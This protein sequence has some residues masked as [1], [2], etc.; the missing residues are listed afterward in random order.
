MIK[1]LMRTKEASLDYFC[2]TLSV[3]L[4]MALIEE[5]EPLQTGWQTL[6]QSKTSPMSS[7]TPRNNAKISNLQIL[8]W[9]V[10]FNPLS[11]SI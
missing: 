5:D 11:Q 3:N 2:S 1:Q 9:I 10:Y 8:I 4:N 7:K 6:E